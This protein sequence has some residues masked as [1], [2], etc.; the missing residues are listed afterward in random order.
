MITNRPDDN[1]EKAIQKIRDYDLLSFEY[2]NLVADV[3]G[4]IE[5]LEENEILDSLDREE[6]LIMLNNSID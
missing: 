2:K 4:S 6:L 5:F 1:Y 3:K